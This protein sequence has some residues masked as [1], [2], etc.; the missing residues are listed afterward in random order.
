MR[1]A[2]DHKR[3][4]KQAQSY[5]PI[6]TRKSPAQNR[7]AKTKKTQEDQKDEGKEGS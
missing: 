1:K 6:R 7:K 3:S 2:K 5:V 4:V